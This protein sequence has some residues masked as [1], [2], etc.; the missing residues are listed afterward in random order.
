MSVRSGNKMEGIQLQSWFA[1]WQG[2]A[3]RTTTAT[4]ITVLCS[5]FCIWFA[6]VE[7]PE[8]HYLFLWTQE[9]RGTGSGVQLACTVD[10]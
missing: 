4:I 3:P 8:L 10:A 6:N 2:L 9:Q 5:C 7:D 1:C